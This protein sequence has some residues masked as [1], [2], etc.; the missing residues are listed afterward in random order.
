MQ[1]GAHAYGIFSSRQNPTITSRTSA[2]YGDHE[3]EA[4]YGVG[5]AVSQ[6]EG[7]TF[8]VNAL[9]SGG[10]AESAGLLRNDQIVTVDG[11]RPPDLSALRSMLLGQKGTRVVIGVRRPGVQHVISIEITRGDRNTTLSPL[12]GIGMGFRPLS[13]GGYLV[14]NIVP[15]SAADRAGIKHNDVICICNGVLLVNKPT[16]FLSETLSSNAAE[17]FT[18]G[19]KRGEGLKTLTVTVIN[20]PL[21]EASPE[22]AADSGVRTIELRETQGSY[23][24]NFYT[25]A[26]GSV[27]DSDRSDSKLT[28]ASSTSYRSGFY[29]D[30]SRD[31][32]DY[33]SDDSRGQSSPR[34]MFTKTSIQQ[35]GG[36]IFSSRSQTLPPR[37]RSK[38]FQTASSLGSG[39]ELPTA[40]RK[41]REEAYNNNDA[42][43]DPIAH[44][45][46][47]E[48]AAAAAGD[49]RRRYSPDEL[50]HFQTKVMNKIHALEV[51]YEDLKI[52]RERLKDDLHTESVEKLQRLIHT[53]DDLVRSEHHRQEAE[54]AREEGEV[55]REREMTYVKD[56]IHKMADQIDLVLDNQTRMEHML[57]EHDS[58]MASFE[59]SLV[60]LK[61]EQD[62][63][64]EG[65]EEMQLKIKSS[66]TMVEENML[67]RE[68][69]IYQKL[70]ESRIEIVSS[71]HADPSKVTD[72]PSSLDSELK[73]NGGTPY[74]PRKSSQGKETLYSPREKRGK[75][76]DHGETIVSYAGFYPVLYAQKCVFSDVAPPNMRCTRI[77]LDDRM[78]IFQKNKDGVHDL[79]YAIVVHLVSQKIWAYKIMGG[80]AQRNRTLFQV[81]GEDICV[82]VHDDSGKID[83]KK[84]FVLKFANDDR[85]FL[86]SVHI[87]PSIPSRTLC[88]IEAVGRSCVLFAHDVDRKFDLR[89]IFVLDT[90]MLTLRNCSEIMNLN[91]EQKELAFH[92]ISCTVVGFKL[93]L[94]LQTVS[95]LDL[96]QVWIVDTNLGMISTPVTLSEP[97]SSSSSVRALVKAMKHSVYLFVEEE[98]QK[99]DFEQTMMIDMESASIKKVEMEGSFPERWK[100]KFHILDEKH[101]LTIRVKDDGAMD[102]TE[103]LLLDASDPLKLK[104]SPLTLP[105]PGIPWE[106]VRLSVFEEKLLATSSS[107]KF[108]R[109]V[110]VISPLQN[111]VKMFCLDVRNPNVSFDVA[112]Q[113]KYL[114][115]LPR[116]SNGKLIVGDVSIIDMKQ[117]FDTNS[118]S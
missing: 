60:R 107:S 4:L 27:Y 116:D 37:T 16:N 34:L 87:D 86:Q 56:F 83:L 42:P 114:V 49:E 95:S 68:Q 38:R 65:L 67:Q 88:H 3:S 24:A 64:I 2:A 81:V 105:L 92:G 25:D 94:V 63:L 84:L 20:S 39:P 112:S 43:S 71:F 96:S 99:I 74:T 36:M 11:K 113:D 106:N 52:A 53:Y 18:L 59:D 78:V 9:K 73:A 48:A 98:E 13:S 46:P 57:T 19:I 6:S 93:V 55:R 108:R 26:G 91:P 10:P 115:V 118:T 8:R 100:G 75:S 50:T 1:R 104:V 76:A 31:A 44:V 30:S 82:F 110:G 23:S 101:L 62:G 15:G 58:K 97:C 29:S 66:V 45:A 17:S 69:Q 117:V 5:A 51:L 35:D 109:L 21:M 33:S 12:V 72:S 89:N 14:T 22:L 7:K 61:Q 47:S 70:N 90:E 102:F 111:V 32:S 28:A 54:R 80:I 85:M 103:M 41:E 77:F 40:T 79:Q